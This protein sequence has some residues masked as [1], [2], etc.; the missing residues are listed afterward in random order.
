MLSA[1]L[2]FWRKDSTA[3][4]KVPSPSK[5]VLSIGK[6]AMSMYSI[7]KPLMDLLSSIAIYNQIHTQSKPISQKQSRE[8]KKKQS[9]RTNEAT[10]VR[11]FTKRPT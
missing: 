6:G 1:S 3:G 8:R 11:G 4:G 10:V 5:S 7:C 9:T 2:I